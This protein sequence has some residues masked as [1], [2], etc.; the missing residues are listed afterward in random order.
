MDRNANYYC[1]RTSHGDRMICNRFSEYIRVRQRHS[2]AA[3]QLVT[4]SEEEAW[5]WYD[6]FI[7]VMREDNPPQGLVCSYEDDDALRMAFAHPRALQSAM[8]K[9][10]SSEVVWDSGASCCISH[11]KADFVGPIRKVHNGAQLTGIVSGLKIEGIGTVNWSVIDVNG[12]I[13]SLL[14][15]CY[16]VPRSNQRLLSTAAF[17]EKYPNNKIIIG[18]PN[19]SIEANPNN[20]K[21]SGIDVYLNQLNNLPIST[22]FRRKAVASTSV[23]LASE[24]TVLHEENANLSAP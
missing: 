3:I 18:S 8:N 16:Y 2:I 22:C 9:E 23:A 6:R 20:A 24:I 17:S 21:E 13:R 1:I 12:S 4:N 11:D 19:W 7:S 14:L 15:P 5:Q 10:D